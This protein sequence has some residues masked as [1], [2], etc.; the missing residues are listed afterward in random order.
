MVDRTDTRQR[1]I[2]TF[3]QIMRSGI[4]TRIKSL[5]AGVCISISTLVVLLVG[6]EA[7]L[8][9]LKINTKSNVRFLHG[10]GTT[11][12]P[13]AYYRHTKEG[14]SEGHF[15]SHG[16]RDRE[17]TYQKS[18][19]TYR[20]LVMGDSQVEAL[21]VSLE[22]SFPA[23]LEQVLNEHTGS[24]RFEVLSLGQSGF[25]T[26][27]E[28]MR[29]LNF[30]IEYFPD[31]VLV[32]FTTTNDFRD[33]SRFLSR[34]HPRFYFDFDQ[35]RNLV[36]DRSALDI[37]E[38]DLTLTKRLFQTLKRRSYLASLISERVFLLRTEL[39]EARFEA[40]DGE[41]GR[42]EDSK[43]VSQFSGLNIYLSNLHP[44]WQEAFDVTREILLKFR[45]SVEE[46]GGKFVLVTNPGAEQVYR[47]V[48]QQLNSEYERVFDYELPDRTLEEF[49]K[50][51]T[52][53]FLP[54]KQAF[55]NYHLETGTY[56]HGFD[57]RKGGHWNEHGHRVAAEEI[58]KFLIK[59][60]VVSLDGT[61][62]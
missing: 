22:N 54:L 6:L 48:A 38:K 21:Q 26:A 32:L 15:N 31:I 55:Q 28:Y 7:G 17:R 60:H 11:Y 27:E 43:K 58:Y 50:K 29:Y 4:N 1:G 44:R 3:N 10:K 8:V 36:L 13:G 56:L 47:D 5:V 19:D 30:G 23:L 39:H 61:S 42:V 52:I 51:E 35:S 14:F 18:A 9:M 53:V 59:K 20:I 57:G 62:E 16:F 37:Y 12:M 41:I 2:V 25:G 45:D 24:G 34:E 40:R 33:N 46:R 49:S